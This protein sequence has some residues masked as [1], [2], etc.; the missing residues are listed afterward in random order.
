MSITFSLFNNQYCA[1][2]FIPDHGYLKQCFMFNSASQL[3]S[4]LEQQQ[5]QQHKKTLDK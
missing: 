1:Q 3:I 2:F 4:K 5:Q